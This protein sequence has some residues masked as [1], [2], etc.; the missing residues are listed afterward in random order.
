[1]LGKVVV[2]GVGLIGGSL[3]LALRRRGKAREVVGVGRSAERLR[4]AQLLGAVDS[5]TTDP[6]EGVKGADLVVVATPIGAIVPTLESLAPHLEPG[7]VVTDVGSTKREIVEA[8][9][10]L[11]AKYSFAF[12]GG[13]PMAG[14]ERTGV[15][16]ADPYL[17]E[18][19]YY[20]LTPTPST[21]AE[22][23]SRVEE[24][25]EA[26]GA[27]KVAIPPDLHDYYVAAVSHLPHC[28]ASALCNLIASLPEKEAILPLAAGGFRDTTRVAA[29]D[30]ALWRDILLTNT[31]PLRELLALLLQVLQEL[32]GL[33]AKKD[34]RELEEWLRRA[35]TLRKEVPTKSK[36]YL[37][38]LHEIVVTVPDRPG[39]IAHLASLLAAK[40][41]NIADIEIL[42]AREGEGGTIRL[43]FTRSEAQEKA[44]ETL[45]A[46]GIEVRKRGG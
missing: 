12:V 10:K 13:H 19:A 23:I 44:Y 25:V 2:V 20:I 39:V 27:R 14:S 31:D 45:A 32:E 21:P 15:E 35:Q 22:A 26:V 28:L 37:P 41:I 16:N 6:A 29:G 1:M 24:L 4:Q 36:G 3:G 11:A 7:T 18:N 43:A 46:A 33:L 5:F 42:R 30:P 17:F 40:D 8:A 38:E 34:A 9:E